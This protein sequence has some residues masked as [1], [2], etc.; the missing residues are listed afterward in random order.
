METREIPYMYEGG[1]EMQDIEEI[2]SEPYAKE[3]GPPQEHNSHLV[4]ITKFVD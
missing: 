4:N 3:Q 1:I 2:L